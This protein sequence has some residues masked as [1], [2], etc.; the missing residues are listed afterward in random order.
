MKKAGFVVGI[1]LVYLA[2]ALTI[3]VS[4]AMADSDTDTIRGYQGF[5]GWSISS[6]PSDSNS[7]WSNWIAVFDNSSGA[8]VYLDS[9]K[10]KLIKASSESSYCEKA[11]VLSS[12]WWNPNGKCTKLEFNESSQKCEGT[13]KQTSRSNCDRFGVSNELLS[14]IA[15]EC[16]KKQACYNQIHETCVTDKGFRDGQQFITPKEFKDISDCIDTTNTQSSPSPAASPSPSSAASPT[17]SSPSPSPSTK[18]VTKKITKWELW[19]E[20]DP[21][22]NR[23][24]AS[25]TGGSISF[26]GGITLPDPSTLPSREVI[27][28]RISYGY[29]MTLYVYFNKYNDHCYGDSRDIDSKTGS[30]NCKKVSFTIRYT[31]SPQV[32]KG[33]FGCTPPGRVEFVGIDSCTGKCL[34]ANCPPGQGEG[35]YYVCGDDGKYDPTKTYGAC[36]IDCGTSCWQ[37]EKSNASAPSCPYDEPCQQ[38]GKNGTRHCTGKV[39]SN[40]CMH[41]PG[42]DTE[43]KVPKGSI[44]CRSGAYDITCTKTSTN[45]NNCAPCSKFPG[46]GEAI[47]KQCNS[48]G[49]AWEPRDPECNSKCACG[50]TGSVP[51]PKEETCTYSE[52]CLPDTTKIRECTGTPQEGGVCKWDSTG[53]IDP[54]CRPCRVR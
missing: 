41:T 39:I 24:I 6:S 35:S 43:C 12:P 36:Y 1:S 49:T 45:T 27:N 25:Q 29:S 44:I 14:K 4:K 7:K 47:I 28:G 42:C 13:T 8:E 37:D 18:Q 30:I 21:K 54:A 40:Q 52:Q 10:A 53:K 50:G 9:N 51:G 31:A 16:N 34:K 3:L 19:W 15:T 46:T 11:L 2:L 5:I 26:S 48:E 22:Q 38:G 17:T 33:N 23:P 32:M 20:T